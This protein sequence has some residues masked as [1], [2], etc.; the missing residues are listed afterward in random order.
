[1]M[2]SFGFG[3]EGSGLSP[4]EQYRGFPTFSCWT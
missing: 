1:M 4:A 3:F 2:L